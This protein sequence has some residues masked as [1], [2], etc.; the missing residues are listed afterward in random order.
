MVRQGTK[1][2]GG[3]GFFRRGCDPSPP[4][5]ESGEQGCRSRGLGS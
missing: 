1:G 2:R 3:V 4:A 5:R